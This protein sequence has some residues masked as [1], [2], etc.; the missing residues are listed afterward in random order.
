M[1]DL[2]GAINASPKAAKPW[3]ELSRAA[4][5]PIV[6]LLLVMV[7]HYGLIDRWRGLDRVKGV[8]DNFSLS[9]APRASVSVYPNDAAWK[10][11]IDLIQKI[12]E[13]QIA[14]RQAP[15]NCREIFSYLVNAPRNRGGN[16]L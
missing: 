2:M 12:L 6:Y 7:E 11:L 9:Y 16:K 4:V 5:L 14:S 3:L 15:A 8:A 1:E 13:G 10:P